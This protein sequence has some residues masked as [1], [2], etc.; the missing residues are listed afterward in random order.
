MAKSIVER[1]MDQSVMMIA[2]EFLKPAIKGIKE[3]IKAIADDKNSS[4]RRNKD[5]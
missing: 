5:D 3:K 1:V 2:R 4:G